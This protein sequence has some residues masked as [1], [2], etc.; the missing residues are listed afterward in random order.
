MT[1][2]QILVTNNI[3]LF[4]ICATYRNIKPIVESFHKSK[5]EKSLFYVGSD[6]NINQGTEKNQ[7][8]NSD[9]MDINLHCPLSDSTFINTKNPQDNN[10]QHKKVIKKNI[11]TNKK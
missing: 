8:L 2:K 11:I 4:V 6:Y 5:Y 3:A 9:V 7:K 1:Y 10:K